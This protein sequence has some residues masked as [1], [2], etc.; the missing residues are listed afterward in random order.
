MSW[1]EELSKELPKVELHLHLDGSLSPGK[2]W[3]NKNI[4]FKETTAT[5][6]WIIYIAVQSTCCYFSKILSHVFF[7]Q[8][9]LEFIARRASA[10]KIALPVSDP[11]NQIEKWLHH[12]KKTTSQLDPTNGYELLEKIL[13]RC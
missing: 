11:I 5:R 12:Q 6:K 4:I 9:L 13:N 7:K 2:F 8:T 10:R 1:E 3:F